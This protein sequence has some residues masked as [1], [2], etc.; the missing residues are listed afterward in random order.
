[1]SLVDLQC[2]LTP[3]E[4]S[5]VDVQTHYPAN[6][7]YIRAVAVEFLV[8]H[9]KEA[10]MAVM[11]HLHETQGNLRAYLDHDKKTV[12]KTLDC[13]VT[14]VD[15]SAMTMDEL[16]IQYDAFKSKPFD[17][18]QPPLYRVQLTQLANNRCLLWFA[19]SHLI[20]DGM[21]IA[22]ILR[23]IAQH[24]HQNKHTPCDLKVIEQSADYFSID[25]L[26]R[27][28]VSSIKSLQQQLLVQDWTALFIE[29][30]AIDVPD[31]HA[32]TADFVVELPKQ[33]AFDKGAKGQP[34]DIN[35]YV[36]S[37]VQ[38]TIASTC[39]SS[40][41]L[42][43]VMN[44][45]RQERWLLHYLGFVASGFLMPVQLQEATME[46]C[47]EHNPQWL[48]KSD[49]VPITAFDSCMLPPVNICYNFF[50]SMFSE[51]R[52]TDRMK[53][54]FLTN[55]K[56]HMWCDSVKL[57]V[58]VYIV[59][60]GYLR[61]SLSALSQYVSEAMLTAFKDQLQSLL[62]CKRQTSHSPAKLS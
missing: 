56:H 55:T 15:G 50:G 14:W 2:A 18:A 6:T 25:S 52:F 58:D 42:L 59:D 37:M 46:S 57:S 5:L 31:Y 28:F 48:S 9:Q 19:A 21:A 61:I 49:H 8:A 23:R 44:H 13:P 38:L 20:M 34:Y 11:L 60:G 51:K 53:L 22:G 36:L 62:P 27:L 17:L 54:T 41:F 7:S 3:Q 43:K 24:L 16:A 47:Y 12:L 29:K 33:L 45:Q 35:A 1:M 10:L 40:G 32:H 30:Q 26:R 39:D 4:Q